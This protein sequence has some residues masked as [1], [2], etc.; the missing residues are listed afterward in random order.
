MNSLPKRDIWLL[1]AISML[2]LLA[3]LAGSE[4]IARIGWP[5]Q[6]SNTCVLPDP[7]LSFRYRANCSSIMKAAEGPWYTNK[8]NDCG[9]RSATSCR[10]LQAGVRRVALIGTSLSEGYLVEYPNTIGERLAA[11]LSAMCGGPVDVQNL[12]ATGYTGKRLAIRMEEALALRPDAVL[13][14]ILPVDIE[15]QLVESTEPITGTTAGATPGTRARPGANSTGTMDSLQRRLVA[16]LRESRAIT[17][18]Q[19]FLFLKQ[20]VYLSLYLR[21]GDKADYLRPPFTEAWQERLRRFDLLLA[22]LANQALRGHVP[23]SLAFVPHQAQLLLMEGSDL[24]RGIDSR[25]LIRAL[26]AMAKRHG[27]DFVDSSEAL[28]AKG[29]INLLYYPVDGHP[30]GRGQP[31][32]ALE[33]AH[34]YVQDPNS[35][36]ADCRRP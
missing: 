34:R 14:T 25:A 22:E 6:R 12:A 35:P 11:D 7:S 33:I 9:Y 16:W 18:A 17:I 27:I 30:T 31:L 10:P 29:N 26:K 8:Y 23:L 2:T 32:I 13:L 15:L 21:Y 28:R 20:S 1:P 3:I 4:L 5:E 36:F 24:Q 19:H